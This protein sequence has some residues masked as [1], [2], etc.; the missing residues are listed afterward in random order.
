MALTGPDA[1]QAL[2]LDAKALSNLKRE[3]HAAPEKALAKAA[4][5]FEAMFLQMV[6]KQMRE[7]LPK[8]G[9]LDSDTMR[10]YTSMFDQQIAQHLSSRGLGLREAIERQLGRA[11]Q[12]SGAAGTPAAGPAPATAPAPSQDALRRAGAVPATPLPGHAVAKARP[13]PAGA[14]A[15][16]QAFVEKLRPH[17][18]A[19]AAASGIPAHLLIAQAGL[20][21]GWGR[22]QPRNADGSASHNLMG[23]KA[24]GGWQG[25]S[26]A[27]STTEFVQ[28]VAVRTVEKFRSYASLAE[29]MRDFAKLLG[30][31]RYASARASAR[32]ND[33]D[34]YARNLQTAGYA[35]DPRYAEKL[36]S[37]I[38]MV[39]RHLGDPAIAGAASSLA[40]GGTAPTQVSAAPADNTVKRTAA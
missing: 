3:A 16:V 2:A 22:S 25:A 29:S 5:Q 18:E 33:G 15:R 14:T 31:A 20:E 17:A 39:S 8:D 19:A 11:L 4:G 9:P 24:T 12:P 30:S 7:T 21:T 13:E 36:G 1:A 23:V 10:T 28:G 40:A 6:L 35:T 26:I 34:G 27:A 37:A 38:R 32:A